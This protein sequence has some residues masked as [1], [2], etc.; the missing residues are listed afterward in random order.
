MLNTYMLNKKISQ[1]FEDILGVS[2]TQ[3]GEWG[4]AFKV[5]LGRKHQCMYAL[6]HRLIDY[7]ALSCVRFTDVVTVREDS[8]V[9]IAD[10]FLAMNNEQEQ[11]T[12]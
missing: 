4:N 12:L 7:T 1:V 3:A 10:V 2:V 8:F 6:F 9:E 11:D 5:R